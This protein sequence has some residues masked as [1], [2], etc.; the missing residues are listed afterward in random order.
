MPAE[1][2][3]REYPISLRGAC[4]ELDN[5]NRVRLGL[6]RGGGH[7][8]GEGLHRLAT[9]EVQDGGEALHLEAAAQRLVLVGIHLSVRLQCESLKVSCDCIP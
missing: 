4:L 3:T 2:C 6:G 9:R 8:R 7:S 5:G 1:L